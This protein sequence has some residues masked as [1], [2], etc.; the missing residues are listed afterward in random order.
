MLT[1]YNRGARICGCRAHRNPLIRT[2]EG[3]GAGSKS[4]SASSRLPRTEKTNIETKYL[5]RAT[6][7]DFWRCLAKTRDTTSSNWVKRMGS[8]VLFHA[9]VFC[10]MGIRSLASRVNIPIRV[11]RCVDGGNQNHRVHGR[12][13]CL[14]IV[15]IF[16]IHFSDINRMVLALFAISF[17]DWG[18]KE[19]SVFL[20]LAK[21]CADTNSRLIIHWLNNEGDGCSAW[22]VMAFGSASFL[23]PTEWEMMIE[24]NVLAPRRRRES[25]TVPI[26]SDQNL[27]GKMKHSMVMSDCLACMEHGCVYLVFF[28]LRKSKANFAS[29]AILQVK[30]KH[31]NSFCVGEKFKMR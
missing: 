22:D 18:H 3:C 1:D 14:L 20:S 7:V 28:L 10:G 21:L 30:H 8:C 17:I 5:T 2:T 29:K 4:S 24:R 25:L 26:R 11:S 23:S 12:C 6:F 27:S 15:N 16:S 9:S 13:F 31:W 19:K